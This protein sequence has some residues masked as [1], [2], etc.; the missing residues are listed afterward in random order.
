MFFTQDTQKH[1]LLTV[2]VYSK[3]NTICYN[4]L[5]TPRALCQLIVLLAVND[6]KFVLGLKSKLMKIPQLCICLQ[7]Y[8]DPPIYCALQVGSG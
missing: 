1:G 5:M 8:F 3:R 6:M 4:V 7:N 2:C